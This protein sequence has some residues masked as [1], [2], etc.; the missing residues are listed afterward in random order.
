ME[1]AVSGKLEQDRADRK[2]HEVDMLELTQHTSWLPA[3]W[4]MCGCTSWKKKE[5]EQV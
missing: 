2:T 5:A 4:K 3:D 1:Q